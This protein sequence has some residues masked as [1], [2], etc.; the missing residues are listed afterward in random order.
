LLLWILSHDAK[1]LQALVANPLPLLREALIN[2]RISL[3][4]DAFNDEPYAH[5]WFEKHLLS[6]CGQTSSYAVDRATN[7]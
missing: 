5:H 7:S 2:L 6:G 4:V 1:H 3:E